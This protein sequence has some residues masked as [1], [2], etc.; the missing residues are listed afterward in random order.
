MDFVALEADEGEGHVCPAAKGLG[1]GVG[2][3][4]VQVVD[5]EGKLSGEFVDADTRAGALGFAGADVEEADLV[6]DEAA[7]VCFDGVHAIFG[8]VAVES[9]AFGDADGCADEGGVGAGY[10]A[11]A[12]GYLYCVRVE[13]IRPSIAKNNRIPLEV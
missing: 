13:C 6:P 9:H 11:A 12:K 4:E 8:A 2:E 7:D 10:F 3:F 1:R 5:V